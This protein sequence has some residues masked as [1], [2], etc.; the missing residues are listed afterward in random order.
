MFMGI[1]NQDSPTCYC[2]GTREHMA[3][4]PQGHSDHDYYGNK[5]YGKL[6]TR[7]G[8]V[9][10]A[11]QMDCWRRTP[12]WGVSGGL[13]GPDYGTSPCFRRCPNYEDGG[14]VAGFMGIIHQDSPACHCH[15]TR[16]NIALALQGQDGHDYYANKYYGN[17][18]YQRSAGGKI[19]PHWALMMVLIMI[20]MP[21][22]V[23]ARPP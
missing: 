8:D 9:P 19:R 6:L 2:R 23:Y 11:G 12:G 3:L 15:G 18:Y 14:L 16:E 21:W 1:S 17:Q 20:N 7:S 22:N 13:S 5:Y 10:E 4:A